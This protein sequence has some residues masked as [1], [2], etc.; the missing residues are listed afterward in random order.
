MYGP[1]KENRKIEDQF[2]NT[3]NDDM[4]KKNDDDD[5]WG[6]YPS[7]P[8]SINYGYQTT[9]SSSLESRYE[10]LFSCYLLNPVI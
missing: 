7:N 1:S 5:G 2:T 8:N 3:L 6:S 4:N 9:P 10:H